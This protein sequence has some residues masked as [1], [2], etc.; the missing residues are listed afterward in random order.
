M[1]RYLSIVANETSL[2][3]TRQNAI[4]FHLLSSFHPPMV[5]TS[6]KER[7]FHENGVVLGGFFETKKGRLSAS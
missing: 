4:S 2:V 7:H 6:M 5:F 3:P 1:T